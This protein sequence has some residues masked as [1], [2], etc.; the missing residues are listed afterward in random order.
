MLDL[1][2]FNIIQ[3]SP[4]NSDKFLSLISV[5]DPFLFLLGFEPEYPQD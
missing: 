5:N 4:S 2:I 1:F 3:K